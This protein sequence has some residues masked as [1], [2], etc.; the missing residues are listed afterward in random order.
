LITTFD[1]PS[2]LAF[3]QT[4]VGTG[5]ILPLAYFIRHLPYITRS[6]SSALESFD[7]ALVEAATT[8][9]AP[10]YRVILRVMLPIILASIA[11]GFLFTFV[12]A[13]VEFPCSELLYQAEAK[14]ISVAIFSNMRT[15]EFGVA[16]AQ[17][18]LLLIGIY[19]VSS[20]VTRLFRINTSQQTFQF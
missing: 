2:W 17:G 16:S 20:F 8:L 18:I 1:K 12:S 19:A 11:S 5:V 6:V 4:L 15:G 3:G 9:G 13:V 7:Y 10:Y 14:P